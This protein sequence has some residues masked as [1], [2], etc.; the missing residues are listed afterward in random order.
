MIFIWNKNVALYISKFRNEKSLKMFINPC[1]K[2]VVGHFDH[3]KKYSQIESF[4]T[5]AGFL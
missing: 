3:F 2:L 5:L 4:D 1:K